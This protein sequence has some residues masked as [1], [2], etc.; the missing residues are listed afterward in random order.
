MRA[1]LFQ[2]HELAEY[3]IVQD[4]ERIS[5]ESCWNA[6]CGTYLV[7]RFGGL[8]Y[9]FECGGSAGLCRF[10]VCHLD[11]DKFLSWLARRKGTR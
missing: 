9:D 5:A 6:A 2:R 7:F 4:S 11:E 1:M 3:F 10:S 8:S